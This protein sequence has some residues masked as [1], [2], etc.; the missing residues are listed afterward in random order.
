M[1]IVYIEL[2][3]IPH[4]YIMCTFYSSRDIFLI[5]TWCTLYSSY[6]VLRL[7]CICILCSS[8]SLYARYVYNVIFMCTLCSLDYNRMRSDPYC[9]QFCQATSP[10]GAGMMALM[11]FASDQPN[12]FQT[13]GEAIHLLAHFYP[14]R[15]KAMDTFYNV[16]SQGKILITHVIS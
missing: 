3:I 11:K 9:I 13:S 4:M 10:I 5:C 8:C 1:Y 15:L 14:N 6:Y 7:S 2:P 16:L 12:M